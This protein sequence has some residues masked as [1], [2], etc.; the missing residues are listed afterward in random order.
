MSCWRRRH[1]RVELNQM[2][3]DRHGFDGGDDALLCPQPH[4]AGGSSLPQHEQNYLVRERVVHDSG[5]TS[6][7]RRSRS[8][9]VMV[10]VGFIPRNPM[11]DDLRRVATF[12]YQGR[13]PQAS[14]RDAG[15]SSQI[16][17]INPTATCMSSLRDGLLKHWN[18]PS[19]SDAEHC[20]F[21]SRELSVT[22]P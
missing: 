13:Y 3:T 20:S 5:F 14:L 22:S 17:G 15:I 12:E 21:A 19:T 8:D 18:A 9:Y 16:R 6:I 11:F 2:N 4:S 10:A 7:C 1:R